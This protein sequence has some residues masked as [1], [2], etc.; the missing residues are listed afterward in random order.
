MSDY[1]Y[2]EIVTLVSKSHEK[3]DMPLADAI[4]LVANMPDVRERMMVLILREGK[5]PIEKWGEIRAIYE[6][7]DFPKK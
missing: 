3:R 1:D 6:R 5:P 2:N 4:R 7:S